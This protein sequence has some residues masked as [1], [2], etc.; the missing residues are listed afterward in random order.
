MGDFVWNSR[1][2]LR[3]QFESQASFRLNR[4]SKK[5]V[6]LKEKT[7]TSKLL[8][9]SAG[10]CGLESS[11]FLPVGVKLNI[12]LDR[13]LLLPPEER[14]KKSHPSKIMGVV[15]TSRQVSNRRYRLGIQFEKISAEDTALIRS[16]IEK[17]ER[18]EDK[19]II[20]PQ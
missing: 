4:S 16:V 14:T 1:K 8:D 2:L 13:A 19:R 18:R 17:Q 11:S 10:G 6:R 5:D 9:L 20:F 15:R 12:F 7:V 3:V